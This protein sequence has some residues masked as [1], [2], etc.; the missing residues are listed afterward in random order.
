MRRVREYVD[1]HL[2]DSIDLAVLAADVIRRLGD[3]FA[4]VARRTEQVATDQVF[5]FLPD[6]GGRKRGGGWG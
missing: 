1:G 5:Q 6:R 2:S 4:L 3:D